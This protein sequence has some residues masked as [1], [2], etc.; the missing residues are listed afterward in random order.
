MKIGAHV[1]ASGGVDKA[2]DRAVEIGAEAIQVFVSSPRAW[3]FRAPKE[4]EVLAFRE[5]SEETGVGPAFFH[6][7][8]LV[9]M[10]GTPDLAERSVDSLVDHMNAA[11]QL[12]AAGVIFHLGSHRGAGLENVYE[13]VIS[14]LKQVIEQTPGETWLV[15]ENSAGMGSH[16]GASFSEIGRII[17]S[18]GSPRVKVCLDTQHSYAAGYNLADSG[19]IGSV[20]E[21]LDREIGV[22]LLAAV[23]ANDSK[24]AL[25]SGVDR[26]EDIGEGSIG[27]AGFE[28][29]MGHDAF[30]DVP[31]LL[32]VPGPEKKGPDRENVDRLKRVRERLGLSP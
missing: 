11:G 21:E 31:F 10:G 8:Y 27:I 24:M 6:G 17:D 25:G 29:I 22:S 19:S 14:G 26:H 13:Q 9:N 18:I 20:M 5:K 2:I 4:D 23:H 28:T 30:R 7:S 15:I 12:G 16:I 3:R 32:E 1:S